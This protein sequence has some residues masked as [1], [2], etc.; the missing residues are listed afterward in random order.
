MSRL[1]EDNSIEDGPSQKQKGGDFEVF[2]ASRESTPAGMSKT[3][4]Y[5]WLIFSEGLASTLG[6]TLLTSAVLVAII[7]VPAYYYLGIAH[8]GVDG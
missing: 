4:E 6:K 8:S 2:P 3:A 7:G 1:I 5:P